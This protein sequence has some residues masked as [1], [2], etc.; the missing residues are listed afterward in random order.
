MM[1]LL[2]YSVTWPIYLIVSV[3]GF[4]IWEIFSDGSWKQRKTQSN[5]AIHWQ[6][7]AIAARRLLR[8][9][10]EKS[11]RQIEELKERKK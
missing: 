6:N 1:K 10:E 9:S 7:E 11:R 4:L 2:I 8:E 3:S 5:P